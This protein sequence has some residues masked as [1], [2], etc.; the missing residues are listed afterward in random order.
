MRGSR[1]AKLGTAHRM[2][3]Y[4][5]NFF[6]YIPIRPRDVA[7]GLY[8]TGAGCSSFPPGTTYP[9][10]VH[11]DMYD[12]TWDRG[13]KLPEYQVVYITRGRGDFE[14]SATGVVEITAGTLFVLFPDVWH[15]YQC[16]L[17]TGWDEWWVGFA[18][19]TIDRIV[20]AGFFSPRSA[21][22]RPG[23]QDSLLQPFRQL[24]GDIRQAKSGFPQ[25]LAADVMR[26]LAAI[27]ETASLAPPDMHMAGPHEVSPLEDRLVAEALRI[28]WGESGESINVT[29]L[30]NRLP[31]TRRSLER[32]FHDRLGRTVLDEIIRCRVER[33]ARLLRDT[34]LPIR[35]VASMAGF[36]SADNMGRAFRRE[37]G[38]S[39]RE[40]RKKAHQDHPR[41]A[42]AGAPPNQEQP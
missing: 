13:R 39:P 35:A 6:R 28:I 29:E 25:R 32:R 37:T 42:P 30:A 22:L 11:P 26:I 33:A 19:E 40:F 7:W 14:S 3:E 8:V 36:P 12:F 38:L 31:V 34:D 27:Q 41:R 9:P 4:G 5:G 24:L 2:R 17:K 15:R 23:M 1:S 20:Q 21:V 10:A 18:G 16:S